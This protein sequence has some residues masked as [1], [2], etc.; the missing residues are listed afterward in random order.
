[1]GEK[2]L[3]SGTKKLYAQAKHY[4][5]SGTKVGRPVLQA[6]IGTSVMEKATDSILV[7][8]SGFT[9]QALSYAKEHQVDGLKHSLWGPIEIQRFIDELPLTSYENVIEPI[10]KRWELTRNKSNKN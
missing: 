1:V 5:K 7:C 3:D 8:S 4:Y 6:L 2:Y 10:R 9:Q